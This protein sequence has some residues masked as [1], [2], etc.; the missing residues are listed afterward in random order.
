MISERLRVPRLPAC[1][2][3]EPG[4]EALLVVIAKHYLT[5]MLSKAGRLV[6]PNEAAALRMTPSSPVPLWRSW[7]IAS[8]LWSETWKKQLALSE[9]SLTR[10]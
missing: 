8:P 6:G 2:R 1:P 7:G 5:A 3:A 9:Q 4:S 10:D